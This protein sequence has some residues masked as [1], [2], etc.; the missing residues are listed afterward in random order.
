MIQTKYGDHDGT[1]WEGLC[2]SVFKHKFFDEG[3]QAVEASPGDYGLEGF[4]LQSGL[5]FQ[6]YCP[7]KIYST[8]TLSKKLRKKIDDDLEK[9][10]TYELQIEGLLTGT[11]LKRWFLVT[12]DIPSKSL[13]THARKKQ[14]EVRGWNL[15]FVDGTFC[16]ELHDGGFYETEIAHIRGLTKNHISID[17]HAS[18]EP[19][20]AGG[21]QYEKNLRRKANLRVSPRLSGDAAT[22][23]ANTIFQQ[24]MTEF[25]KSD[26]DLA[27]ISVRAP[28]VYYALCR[29]LNVFQRHVK[30]LSASWDGTPFDLTEKLRRELEERVNKTLGDGF[31]QEVAMSIARD[32][33]AR[34]L[35]ICSLD[36]A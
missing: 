11:K 28:A 20:D 24:S 34:W 17:D 5:A 22:E 6:C 2:Q 16:V 29:L 8:A 26:T 35:A 7:E 4:T 33:V 1:S 21:E 19:I 12:P 30:E 15:S 27:T 23:A 32:M 18:I 14:I 10:K 36:Y 31:S 13:L 9:L 25:L 3:Y